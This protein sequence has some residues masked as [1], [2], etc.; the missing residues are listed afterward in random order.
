MSIKVKIGQEEKKESI[1]LKLNARK[2]IDGNIMIFDHKD[3][4]IVIIPEKN[5]IITF[6]K[7]EMD[8]SIYDAQDRLFDY[9]S[10]KGVVKRESIEAGDV[11]AS[12]QSEYPE[13]IEGTNTTQLVMFS[14]GKWIEEERPGMEMEEYYENEIENRLVNPDDEESTELGEVPHKEK[15]GSVSKIGRNNYGG[16]R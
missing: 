14:V 10:K 2:S 7:K 13:S 3:I 16:F 6:P 8:D 4:D 12:V 15:Q 1:S 9:L 5:Q 11:Y